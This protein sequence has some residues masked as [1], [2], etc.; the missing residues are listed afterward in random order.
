MYINLIGTFLILTITCI[1][2]LVAYAIYY[3]CDLLT[4][5]KI[6]KGEQ[7]LP[8]LVMDL[9]GNLPGIPGLFVASIY[10]ASLSTVSSGLNSLAT[11]C[12]KDLIQPFF[13]KN[14]L[15]NESK[16]TLL[17]KVIA[18]SFGFI[19]VGIA[20]SCQYLSTTVLQLSL[21]IFG[22]LGGPLLGVISLGIFCKF[23]NSFG[24]FIGLLFSTAINIWIGF[25]AVLYN[26][27]P[28]PKPVSTNGCENVRIINSNKTNIQIN[29]EIKYF[30]V[31]EKC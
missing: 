3:D 14:Y 4:S 25:G 1:A 7:I 30:F 5:N 8:Y 17:S 21:S 29:E 12:I 16:A 2:G 26:Q 13:F 10:S 19:T 6:D 22:I 23:A 11:V 15:L 9:F 27:S 20:Y 24:A 31:S 18:A 28:T